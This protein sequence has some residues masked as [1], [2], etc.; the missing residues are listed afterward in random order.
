MGAGMAPEAGR[1]PEIGSILKEARARRGLDI[2]TVEEQTKIRTKYLRALE[3]GDWDALP[4][5]AY[6][7]GFLRTYASLLGLDAEALLDEYRRRVEHDQGH[8]YGLGEPVLRERRLADGGGWGRDRRVLIAILVASVAI[9]LLVLGL[10]AGSDEEDGKGKRAAKQ[11]RKKR[12][13]E[14]ENQGGGQPVPDTVAVRLVARSPTEVCLVSGDGD[15]LLDNQVLANQDEETFEAERF[16]LALSPGVVDLTL[17]GDSQRLESDVPLSYQVTP[18][19]L[20]GE[21]P[22]PNPDCP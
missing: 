12:D 22:D 14:R 16:E 4:G 8:P 17:N 10:T 20:R 13:R 11:E 19:G 3:N 2:R 5:P 1:E 21:A 9:V 6:T 7:R 15:V 18:R